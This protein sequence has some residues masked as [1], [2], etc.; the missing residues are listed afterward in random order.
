VN[1]SPFTIGGIHGVEACNA[2]FGIPLEVCV[3]YDIPAPIVTFI[4]SEGTTDL[5]LP[6]TLPPLAPLLQAI[7]DQNWQSHHLDAN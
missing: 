6:T 2:S 7:V 3:S 1:H 4:V 5:N